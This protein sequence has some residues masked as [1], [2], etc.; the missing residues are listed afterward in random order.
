M[1]GCRLVLGPRLCA[2]LGTCAEDPVSRLALG[3]VGFDTVMD[4]GMVG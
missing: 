4:S 1:A 3:G 2:L